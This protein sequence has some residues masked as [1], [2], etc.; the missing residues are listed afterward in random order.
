MKKISVSLMVL[1]AFVVAPLSVFAQNT[2]N[3]TVGGRVSIISPL[4]ITKGP[5]LDFGIVA[6][7]EGRTGGTVTIAPTSDE[8]TAVGVSKTNLEQ[9]THA[10]FTLSGEPNYSFGI[11]YGGNAV[12]GVLTLATGLT[13]ALSGEGESNA[14]LNEASLSEAGAYTLNIGGVLT[15][16]ANMASGSYSKDLTVTV[17]YN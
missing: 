6:M 5:D 3:A 10:S 14:L 2:D 8:A 7:G 1:A 9:T 12:G 16:P 11:A 15:V 17:T 13:I 4:T